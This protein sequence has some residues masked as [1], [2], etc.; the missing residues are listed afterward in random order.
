MERRT[1][2]NELGRSIL[3]DTAGHLPVSRAVFHN[4]MRGARPRNGSRS[5]NLREKLV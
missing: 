5:P 3:S 2:C 1:A 4:E